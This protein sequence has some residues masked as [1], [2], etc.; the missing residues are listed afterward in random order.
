MNIYGVGTVLGGKTNNEREKLNE[1]LNY[2]F[3]CMGYSDKEKPKY[4]E[5]IKQIKEGDIIVAKSYS[6]EPIYYVKAIGYVTSTE[7]PDKVPEEFRDKSGISV[8][9]F[10]K[11]K[12]Y[13]P[14]SGEVFKLGASRP[15]TIYLETEDKN[16]SVI[17]EIIKYNYKTEVK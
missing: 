13:I 16:I 10:K 7:K 15:N 1:Y 17:K 6:L 8:L 14:L 12:P 2:E 9:W 11:F 4:A 3:W 5:L